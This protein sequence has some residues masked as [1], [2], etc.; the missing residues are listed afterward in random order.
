MRVL[1]PHGVTNERMDEVADYY[2]FRPQDGEL[3]PT[4]SAKAEAIVVDG[5]VQ[6]VDVT[7]GGSGY[8]SPP[9]ATIAGYPKLTLGVQLSFDDDLENN[10][11]VSGVTVKSR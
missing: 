7:D 5:K 10:G 9:A 4:R 3:W 2:R 1:E 6:R 8:C 11:V